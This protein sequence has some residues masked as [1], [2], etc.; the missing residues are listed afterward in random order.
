M[1]IY[2]TKDD[3]LET[4]TKQMQN[5]RA[6]LFSGGDQ[7]SADLGKLVTAARLSGSGEVD[8]AARTVE[9]A[10][11]LTRV[12]NWRFLATNDPKGPTNFKTN[13]DASLAALTALEKLPVTDDVRALIAPVRASL[14]T[15]GAS[16][17]AVSTAMLASDE[18]FAK[19]MQPL[20]LQQAVAASHA[21]DSLGQDFATATEATAGMISG[22]VAMQK[23]VA[24]GALL[25]G[26]LIAWLV[27]RGI[28]RPMSGMTGAMAKLA[29][30]ET[31]VEVP[32]RDAKASRT[33]TSTV[34]MRKCTDASH[35]RTFAPP[36]CGENNCR[37][38]G[39]Y[40]L[41]LMPP[42]SKSL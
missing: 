28:I 35:S 30:G 34:S 5:A 32:S 33:L 31:A 1:A 40:S 19:Q 7:M 42:V 6:K 15:Y 25:L 23:V 11:L 10:V 18:L 16:F 26:V 20:A 39:T 41:V 17:E 13:A 37:P 14:T 9:A 12:A 2:H 21:A 4:L 38:P 24:G 8:T 22:T 36:M 3:D 29:A 27:G